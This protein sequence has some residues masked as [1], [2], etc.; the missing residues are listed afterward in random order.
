MSKPRR[1]LIIGEHPIKDSIKN[2][3]A[4][5]EGEITEVPKLTDTEFQKQWHDIVVLSSKNNDS[6]QSSCCWLMVIRL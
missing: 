1:I 2:Q 5:F 3:F 6:I 4:L